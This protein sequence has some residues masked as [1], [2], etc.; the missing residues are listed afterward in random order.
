MILFAIICILFLIM[1]IFP[2]Y[3]GLKTARYKSKPLFINQSNARNPRYFAISF[4]RI[5]DKAWKS[6]GGSGIISMS[7]EE[8]I[9]EA[10]KVILLSGEICK[11][12]IY[13]ENS[14]F[15]PRED[16]IFQKEI[17]VKKNAVLKK[18]PMVRAIACVGDLVLG[19]GTRII[20]WADAEG[21]LIAHND[22]DL[23]ISTTSATML[24]VGTNC[25]FKRLYAPEIWLGL[26]NDKY[27]I[28]NNVIIPKEIVISSEIIRNIEYVD[29]EIV[30]EK[31]ILTKT[32]ITKHDITVLGNFVVQGHIRSH[33]DVKIDS[34]AVVHGNIFAE[35]NI[36]IGRNAI[37]LGIVFTQE[38]IYIDDGAVIGQPNKI[39]SVV[40]RG[41]IECGYNCRVYG[42]IGVEGT[43]KVCPKI[44]R[45]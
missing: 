16:I 15:I 21:T 5:F 28:G 35:G 9:I 29:D 25:F 13:A 24:L 12:L 32:I 31:G 36:F 22:C 26:D 42:Y 40:A 4:K 3:I 11:S 20:R 39:K 23:G 6:Y 19:N 34:N 8:K 10:D 7:K 41:N 18:I 1:L 38:N 14:N 2:I 45:E 43:G 33:K 27:H 17:Y 30:N 44:S 37:V